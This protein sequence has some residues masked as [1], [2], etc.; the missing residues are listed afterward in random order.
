[1]MMTGSHAEVVMKTCRSLV[2]RATLLAVGAGVMLAAAPAHAIIV[3]E[4]PGRLTSLPVLAGDVK[5]GWQYMGDTEGFGGIPIGPRAWVAASHT[6]GSGTTRFVYDNAGLTSRLEY[7]STRAALSGDLSVMVLNAGQPDFLAW[8]PVWQSTNNILVDQP[9]YMYGFGRLRGSVVTNDVPAPNTQKGWN[10]GAYD[11]ALSYGTNELEDLVADQSG[12]LYF[13]MNFDQPT[14]ENLLPSTEG[15]YSQF[16]SGGGVFTYNNANAR[17]ELI[18]I[19]SSVDTVSTTAGG[20]PFGASLYDARGY[21]YDT[22]L[23]TGTTNVPLASY[24][25]ALPYKYDVL[26]PY[27]VEVPEPATWSLLGIAAALGLLA[28]RVAYK[29]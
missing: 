29:P 1:M 24:A 28:R 13:Q 17:W 22:T 16:D 2:L 10:W 23:I 14:G 18:G 20:Q 21:Y 9:V 7:Y 12:N 6:V 3:Y 8:A 26:A 5:P 27:I 4:D 19:N 11:F 25:T 15:I